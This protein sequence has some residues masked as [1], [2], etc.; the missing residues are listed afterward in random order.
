MLTGVTT[1]LNYSQH[2]EK[3]LPL[4]LPFFDK[5]YVI[6]SKTDKETIKLCKKFKQVTVIKT[7]VFFDKG[8]GFYKS[9]ALNVVL[10]TFDKQQDLWCVILDAD[11]IIP[12]SFNDKK[13]EELSKDNIY[14]YKR[15]NGVSQ[16]CDKFILGYF[17]LF[18]T[19][20]KY[21]IHNYDTM[22]TS[23]AGADVIF[24]A[25]WP[26][27]NNIFFKNG[28]IKHVAQEA[29]DWCG[30]N[31]LQ[32]EDLQREEDN[33]KILND[34]QAQIL[35]KTSNISNIY[36]QALLKTKL[37]LLEHET[38]MFYK[39]IKHV[40]YLEEKINRAK[41]EINISRK[42]K[43]HLDKIFNDLKRNVEN[44]VNSRREVIEKI[45]QRVTQ[46]ENLV[47]S[48]LY[49]FQDIK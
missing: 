13:I 8:A 15:D 18:N 42:S 46:E 36:V 28:I 3:T 45:K 41:Y 40:E 31:V 23:A 12:K 47:S 21:Y 7:E 33:L 9:K 24:S 49:Q 25:Q 2:L 16:W 17:Q 30:V 32:N 1:C 10:D 38:Q 4:N 27:S 6:T 43:E 35:N 37:T 26:V 34:Q 48:L 20:S 39:S 5:F 44:F 22:F 11:V 29:R 19:N 14:S